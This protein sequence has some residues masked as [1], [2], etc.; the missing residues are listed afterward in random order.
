MLS[1]KP[2]RIRSWQQLI[3]VREETGENRDR[4]SFTTEETE[5]AEGSHFWETKMACSVF[6]A[7]SVVNTRGPISAAS[8][9]LRY[10]AA[11]ANC[12]A[13]ARLCWTAKWTPRVHAHR[14][15]HPISVCSVI[16]GE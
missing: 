13:I 3:N 16:C 9:K 15:V 7:I 2:D 4:R 8:R 10:L 5:I 1:H 14:A 11:I 12:H 6:S